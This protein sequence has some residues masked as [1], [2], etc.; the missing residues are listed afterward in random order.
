MFSESIDVDKRKWY[1][2][3]MREGAHAPHDRKYNRD[4]GFMSS[5][6]GKPLH[7]GIRYE[8]MRDLILGSKEKYATFPVAD[9]DS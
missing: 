2:L 3:K 4:G 1:H 8:T 6:V 7:E 9:F 5:I